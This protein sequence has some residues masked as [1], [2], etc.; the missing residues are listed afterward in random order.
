MMT[1]A[2]NLSERLA[3]FTEQWSPKIVAPQV[4]EAVAGLVRLC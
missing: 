3:K 4:V 1:T 2:I